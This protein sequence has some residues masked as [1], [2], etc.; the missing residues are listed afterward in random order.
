MLAERLPGEWQ[1]ASAKPK[2]TRR[3]IISF[4]SLDD[5]VATISSEGGS[6]F[7]MTVRRDD[8]SVSFI[9][10][11]I[12]IGDSLY[13]D[14]QHPPIRDA[15]IAGTTLRPH[16]FAQCTFVDQQIRLTACDTVRFKQVLTADSLPF[17][18]SDTGLVFTGTSEQLQEIIREHSAELFRPSTG[19]VILRS[20]TPN[21]ADNQDREPEQSFTRQLK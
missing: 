21:E 20:Q 17:V 19:D 11:L 1:L 18:D 10:R 14:L 6:R 13:V 4:G 5:V 15:A 2:P 9:C 3:P 16:F 7:Q 12:K 8:V